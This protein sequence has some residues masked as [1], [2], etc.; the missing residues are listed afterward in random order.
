MANGCGS[1]RD[2]L[3]SG[4]AVQAPFLTVAVDVDA[5]YA[6]F[7]AALWLDSWRCTAEVAVRFAVQLVVQFAM[8]DGGSNDEL[9]FPAYAGT[10]IY[11]CLR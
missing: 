4:T 11:L 1:A 7:D 2:Q 9:I 3:L 10:F 8:Q 6:R 5:D